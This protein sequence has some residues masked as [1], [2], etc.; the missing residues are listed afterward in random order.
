MNSADLAGDILNGQGI[1][2]RAG[3]SD[4]W[5]CSSGDGTASATALA[6]VVNDGATMAR[7]GIGQAGERAGRNLGDQVW[8]G[9]LG[10]GHRDRKRRKKELGV[11]H[12]GSFVN[13]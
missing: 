10:I 7:D 4:T 11:M 5:S 8:D 1:L 3:S 12:L 9:R 13:W 2:S 6:G